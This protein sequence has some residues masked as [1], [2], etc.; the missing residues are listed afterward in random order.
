MRELVFTRNNFTKKLGI[1]LKI[2]IQILWRGS[3]H[4]IWRQERKLAYDLREKSNY[5]MVN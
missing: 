1:P 4:R 3:L 2:T 5:L